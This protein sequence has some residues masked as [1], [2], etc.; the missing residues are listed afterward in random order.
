MD[1]LV[2]AK[3]FVTIVDRGSLTAAADSLDMSRAMVTRNLAQMEEW[4]AARLLHRSTRRLSLTPAGESTLARCRQLLEVAGQITAPDGTDA[5]APHGLLRIACGQ[6]LAQQVLGAAVTDYLR[7]Y[8]QTAVDLVV[9]GR[10]VNLVEERIDLAVRITNEL[11]PN[12]ISRPLGICESVVCAAPA[13]LAEHGTPQRVEDLAVHNCLTYSYFGKSL[14]KFTEATTGEPINVPV[15]G[16]LSANE[17]MA[18]LAAAQEG[19]GV[20]LQPLFAAAPSIKSGHLVRLLPRY[21]PQ[22]LGIHGIY[23]SRRQMSLGLRAMLD[24]LVDWFATHPIGQE[25]RKPV[26]RRGPSR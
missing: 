11:D 9:D 8:S 20:A 13:Y 6:F 18:L 14:W 24:F 26:R 2:A 21:L 22:V 5:D 19:A 3:V 7:R 17:S 1:R 25:S 12:L 15:S 23:T 4:A 10:A 16:N